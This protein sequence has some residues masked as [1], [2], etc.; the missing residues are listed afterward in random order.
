MAVKKYTSPRRLKRAGFLAAV[1]V[2]VFVGGWAIGY[3][4]PKTGHSFFN[5]FAPS[6]LTKAELREKIRGVH[7]SEVYEFK[8]N[9]ISVPD[10]EEPVILDYAF[11][12]AI[13]SLSEDLLAQYK[14]DLGVMVAMDAS[15]GRI[16]AISG[17]IVS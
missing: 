5:P 12:P 8:Q 2:L 9:E 6:L 4:A 1:V 11:D 15:T 10:F 14:P 3:F 13:Q 7:S 17:V 16:L